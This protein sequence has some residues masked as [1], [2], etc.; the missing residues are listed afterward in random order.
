[1]SL[2]PTNAVGGSLAATP[3]SQTCGSEIDRTA[4][5]EAAQQRARGA[6]ERAERADGVGQTD[7]DYQI[8]DREANG[9]QSDEP[10]PASTR[11]Q[12]NVPPPAE[13]DDAGAGPA[14]PTGARIDL[15]G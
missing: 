7:Q 2:G 14:E 6:H 4:H 12:D 11:G 5:D 1:M 15:C 10:P 9:R 8:G 3:L 13:P